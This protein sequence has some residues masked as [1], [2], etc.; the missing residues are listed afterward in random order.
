MHM[1]IGRTL[2]PAAAPIHFRDL[3]SGIAGILRGQ[4]E[5]E[6]FRDE[7]RDYFGVRHCYLVSSG[8]AALTLILLALKE[9]A[10]QRDEV[11]IPAFTCYSVPASIVA[12]GL[13]VRLCDIDPQT[14]DFD[15]EQLLTLLEGKRLLGIVPTHLF[16]LPADVARL[17][18]ITEGRGVFLVE[19]AA[20]AMGSE[21][22]GEKLGTLGDV[23][24]FSLGR[25]K[26]FSTVEGGV[27]LTRCDKLGRRLDQAFA[28]LEEYS[29]LQTLTLFIY[30]LALTVLMRPWLFWL[31]KNL[32]FL[33]LGETVYE[34]DF[35]L[36]K[37]TGLQA[38]LAR[39]W[40]RKL[41]G[42][43]K[44]RCARVSDWHSFFLPFSSLVR[45][46][47]STPLLRF[48]MIMPTAES[49]RT[50]LASGARRGLGI[51]PSYPSAIHHIPELASG[52]AGQEFP[53][54]VEVVRRLITIPVH[55]YVG[56]NDRKKIFSLLS[57]VKDGP[58]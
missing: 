8:Q 11:L 24:F 1:R 42:F 49:A 21:W 31:P 7:L 20:Q 29:P 22:Q 5:T 10:P 43:Q 9:L 45:L 36:R 12:A 16:G 18:R 37:L 28:K 23:G 25:G 35:P 56:R 14:C 48:P 55:G 40:R 3:L 57:Q 47:A 15:F 33:R 4:R 52:F 34:T 46:P 58:Q 13:K 41:K 27:I 53:E 54:A 19:D 39:N 50:F 17:K 6:R 30:A 32:P 26:A 2:P 51:A 44:T 38:G